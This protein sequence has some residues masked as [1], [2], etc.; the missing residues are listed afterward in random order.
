[1]SRNLASYPTLAIILSF[2]NYAYLLPATQFICL[3]AVWKR[4]CLNYYYLCTN[5]LCCF[6]ICCSQYMSHHRLTFLL[7]AIQ[8]LC[9]FV[10]PASSFAQI[11]SKVLCSTT[12]PFDWKWPPVSLTP[13]ACCD[14]FKKCMHIKHAGLVHRLY[15]DL[16]F[17]FPSNFLNGS[18]E[19]SSTTSWVFRGV[20]AKHEIPRTYIHHVLAWIGMRVKSKH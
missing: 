1:M 20:W 7:S 9:L 11:R 16:F 18:F 13:L 3:L 2:K 14:G 6:P 10:S 8:D 17:G 5:F 15:L 4:F 12:L 19:I